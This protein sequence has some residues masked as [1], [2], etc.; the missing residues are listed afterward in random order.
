VKEVFVQA[1][2]VDPSKSFASLFPRV[3]AEVS[4]TS[5]VDEVAAAD[6]DAAYHKQET[7]SSKYRNV[8]DG[9]QQGAASRPAQR[10]MLFEPKS[11]QFVHSEVVTAD[12]HPVTKPAGK[13]VSPAVAHGDGDAKW[14][15]APRKVETVVDVSEPS[16]DVPSARV[17]TAVLTR[18][19]APGVRPESAAMKLAKAEELHTEREAVKVAERALERSAR[20]PRTLGLLFRFVAGS[21]GGANETR[22]IEQVL[23]AAEQAEVDK[24]K[25]EQLREASARTAV[26]K[27]SADAGRPLYKRSTVAT[28]P[29]AKE[30]K[31]LIKKVR[32][33]VKVLVSKHDRSPTAI[34][35]KVEEDLQAAADS[36][37]AELSVMKL[38]ADGDN[39]SSESRMRWAQGGGM[40]MLQPQQNPDDK[41]DSSLSDHFGGILSASSVQSST[42]W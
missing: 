7:H 13:S 42:N 37:E 1:A 4:V 33:A 19:A 40:Q 5:V 2:T 11:G 8:G 18:T 24:K 21:S 34:I 32:P 9:D 38:T 17:P 41:L 26:T 35:N 16:G 29:L 22:A 15:R 14:A 27:E 39:L 10:K 12:Q 25:D 6:A 3:A 23:N 28:K 30:H 36:F 20:E 31:M